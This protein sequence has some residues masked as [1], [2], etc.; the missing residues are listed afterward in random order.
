MTNDP[1]FGEFYTIL[2][3]M[4][5]SASENKEKDAPFKSWWKKKTQ[6]K[7]NN[8]QEGQIFGVPLEESVSYAGAAIAYANDNVKYM[9][10]IPLLIAKCGSFLK[11]EALYTEGIFRLSGSAKRIGELQQIFNTGPDYGRQLDW[12]G[13]SVH[14][15]ANILRRFLNYLPEPVIIQEMCQAFQDVIVL[16]INEE[17][18]VKAYQQLIEKLPQLHQYLLFYL[19]DLLYLFSSY[20][21]ITRMDT[22]NLASVFTPGIL[23]DP[24]CCLDPAHYKTSQRVVQF[25]IEH[26]LCFQMPKSS[27]FSPPPLSPTPLAIAT[28]SPAADEPV[29]S[30]SPQMTTPQNGVPGL[31]INASQKPTSD[32]SLSSPPTPQAYP[33]KDE[34]VLHRSRTLPVKRSKY[35]GNDP[36]QVVQFNKHLVDSST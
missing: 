21:H 16:E 32:S 15:T 24:E 3:S 17:D 26:Q 19:L 9:G 22:F 10:S 23:M 27:L 34:Y 1:A 12:K 18:K 35:G 14:D 2:A 33:F 36:L 31:L 8:K 6:P 28:A 25:L 4:D 29:D 13:Y 20:S 11:E 5:T 30:P 7:S